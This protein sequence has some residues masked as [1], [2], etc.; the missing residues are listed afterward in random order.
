MKREGFVYLYKQIW[1]IS[2]DVV[3]PIFVGVGLVGNVVAFCV[4]VFGP[5]SKS[6]C[7]A[8]YFAANCAV[9]FLYMIHAVVW[10]NI[11][12][13][14]IPKTDFTCKLFV[15]FA[16]SCLQL[17]TCISAII[18]VERS[19]TILFPLFVRTQ[20]MRKRS[21]IVL[22]VITVL[23]PCIQFIKWYY[24]EST[25]DTCVYSSETIYNLNV[26]FYTIIVFLIPFTVILTLNL[27]TVAMLIRQ[28]FRRQA[29]TGGRNHVNVFT[30]LTLLT[31][32]SFAAANTLYT[33]LSIDELLGIWISKQ[34]KVLLFN[35]TKLM[36]YFNSV[37]NP[38]ICFI[39]CK[40]A[41]DDINIFIM[42]VARQARRCCMCGCFQGDILTSNVNPD[43]P[44]IEHI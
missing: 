23:Q 40:S 19:L 20:G 15:S 29:G 37:M 30:K 33:V 35:P 9:D 38:I 25:G 12:F 16:G 10:S 14:I 1:H 32:V 22:L 21:K 5:K 34:T 31:G 18:T 7:C 11:W 2:F 42:A 8:I 28:R 44:A 24:K 27:A 13:K 36:L 26:V 4:W 41:P 6:M 3:W 17:S 39:V 43:T